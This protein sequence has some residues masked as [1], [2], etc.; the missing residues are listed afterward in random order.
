MKIDR[1]YVNT[2][3]YDHVHLRICIA[4]IRYWY[5]DIPVFLIKDEASGK[6]DTSALEKQWK[7]NVLKT[8][9][10]EYGWGFGKL[11]P[12]FLPEDHR[13]LVLDSDTVIT[14]PVLDLVKDIATDF[15][16]DEEVQTDAEL[17][18][19]YYDVD[20]VKQIFPGFVY[21][22]YTFNSGQW[23]GRTGRISKDD[24]APLVNWMPLP[25]LKYPESFMPGDQG[26]LNLTIHHKESQK[27]ISVQRKKFMLWPKNGGAAIV[28]LESI[29]SKKDPGNY[30]IHWAGLKT[31]RL[32]DQERYDILKF[33][34]DHYQKS[35]GFLGKAMMQ[36]KDQYLKLERKIRFRFKQSKK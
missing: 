22:G 27:Q 19:L 9:F 8:E 15:V 18:R 6:F 24:L 25:V 1:V 17:R 14:G 5:P 26:I 2:Y 12:L 7:L 13:F 31:E 23:F 28:D 29:R 36:L 21:P 16:V 10:S 32:Q 20:F 11:E 35:M 4:S 34:L 30:V 33:Y 3:R